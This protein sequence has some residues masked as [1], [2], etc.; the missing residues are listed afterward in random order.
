MEDEKS[1]GRLRRRFQIGIISA[2]IGVVFFGFGGLCLLTREFNLSS[3]FSIFNIIMGI[4]WIWSG[5][6]KIDETI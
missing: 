4:Y 3:I 2:V 6:E 1:E 5:A